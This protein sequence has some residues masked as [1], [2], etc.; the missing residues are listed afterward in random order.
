[1]WG[2]SFWEE[3]EKGKV[4]SKLGEGG[5]TWLSGGLDAGGGVGGIG[6]KRRT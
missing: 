3:I 4:A 1:L 2:F 5:L 6:S